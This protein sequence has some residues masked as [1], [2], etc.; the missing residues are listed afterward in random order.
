MTEEMTRREDVLHGNARRQAG[1]D[2]DVSLPPND[3]ARDTSE[4]W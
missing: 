4:I 1:V 3:Q 2:N